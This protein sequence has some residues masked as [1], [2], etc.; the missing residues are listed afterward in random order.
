MTF[1]PWLP[2]SWQEIRFRLR[3]RGNSVR[4]AIS[5][6]EATFTLEAP[7]GTTEEVVVGEEEVTLRANTA[8]T[9]PLPKAVA[10]SAEP[11]LS[12]IAAR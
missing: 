8:V 3:W 11:G 9:V 6:T 1:N 7:E 5:H 12:E 10:P 2:A 4:V